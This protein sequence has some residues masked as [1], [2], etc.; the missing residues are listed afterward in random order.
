M[1]TTCDLCGK[2][3]DDAECS[4]ACPHDALIWMEADHPHRCVRG[5]VQW[6]NGLTGKWNRCTVPTHWR[7]GG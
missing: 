5:V 4:T 7:D 6:H 3:T 1:I 2:V